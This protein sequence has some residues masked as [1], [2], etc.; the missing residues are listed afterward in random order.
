MPSESSPLV[1]L[2]I[3]STPSMELVSQFTEDTYAK[4]DRICEQPTCAAK[5]LKGDPCFYIATIDPNK[6]GCFVCGSCHL[7]YQKKAATTVRPSSQG[8]GF[9]M[10]STDQYQP[11]RPLPD[12]HGIRRSV[13]AA[14]RTG[15]PIYDSCLLQDLTFL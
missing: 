2:P 14:Q 3:L 6:P 13:N 5:I 4:E 15:E 9:R 12:L 10:P 8:I 1:H 7:R 11:P